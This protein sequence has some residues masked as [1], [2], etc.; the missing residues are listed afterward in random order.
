[1]RESE[2]IIATNR[3]KICIAFDILKDVLPG[4]E[5]GITEKDL[6]KIII[7]LSRIRDNLFKIELIDEEDTK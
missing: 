5:Y 2:Y 7:P 1:M 6:R 4:D 3:S